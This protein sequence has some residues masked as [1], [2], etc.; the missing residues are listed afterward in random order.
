MKSFPLFVRAILAAPAAV[1]LLSFAAPPPPRDRRPDRFPRRSSR[2]RRGRLRPWPDCRDHSGSDRAR[3]QIRADYVGGSMHCASR[4]SKDTLPTADGLDVFARRDA[5]LL[6]ITASARRCRCAPSTAWLA[7][8]GGDDHDL[9]REEATTSNR[10]F[11]RPAGFDSRVRGVL[12]GP[13]RVGDLVLPRRFPQ[14]FRTKR[15]GV[16]DGCSDH[17]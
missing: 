14:T 10:L 5:G 2:G 1:P 8:L 12:K 17:G 15:A 6:K 11:I 9:G 7:R 3:P 13:R 16:R 4:S